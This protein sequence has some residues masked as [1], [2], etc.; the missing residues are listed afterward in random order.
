MKRLTITVLSVVALCGGIA[1]ASPAMAE[2]RVCRGS[3]GAVTL[4]NVRVPAGAT[5]TMNGTTLKGTLTVARDATL[6]ANRIKVNG[7][8]QSQA[9]RFVRVLDSRVDGS[10]QLRQGG[11]LDCVATLSTPTSRSSATSRAPRRSTRTGSVETFSASRRSPLPSAAA[12]SSRATSKTSAAA[13]EAV[14]PTRCPSGRTSLAR[15]PR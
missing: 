8:I 10:I 6:K 12:T 2:E 15:A 14:R 9:H 1:T 11:A 4:D 3:L 13:S 5:C 7:N